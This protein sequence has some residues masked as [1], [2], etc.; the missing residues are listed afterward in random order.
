MRNQR[1]GRSAPSIVAPGCNAP[2]FDLSKM[3]WVVNVAF[4][5]CTDPRYG[6]SKTGP[7]TRDENGAQLNVA[8]V[9]GNFPNVRILVHSGTSVNFINHYGFT[10]VICCCW[11]GRPEILQFFLD[12]KA[13]AELV[14]RSGWTPLIYAAVHNTYEC[15][16]MLV[17]YGVVLDT[18]D[19]HDR[20][21][22]WWASRNGNLQI[23]QLLVLSGANFDVADCTGKTPLITAK[24]AN[25]TA[26]VAYLTIERNWSRR[27]DY[28]TMLNSLKGAATI[29]QIVR[30][31]QCYDVARLIGSYL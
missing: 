2:G 9:D 5:H 31:F 22:I 16:A 25:H 29:S 24:Q 20:G 30:V 26:V 14:D 21:A 8:C 10:P 19:Y 1:I 13:D 23:V 18:V 3:S 11:K 27:R 28:A 12:Q 7:L 15:A 17:Q 4:V 6:S